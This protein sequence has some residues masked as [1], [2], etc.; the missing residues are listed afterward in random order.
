ML[1]PTERTLTRLPRH[2]RRY[3]VSQDYDAYNP[4]DHAVWRFILRRL[5]AHL[6]ERAHPVYLEGLTA[7][8]LGTERIPNLDEM[9]ERLERIGWGAVGVRGFIPPAVFTELLS[10]G[11]LPI[12]ADIRTHEHVDYTPAPDIVHESAGHAPILA[13]ARYA[14]FIKAMAVVSFKAIASVEDQAVFEAIRGL[15][16]VKED[17]TASAEE[18]GHAEARLAAAGR[19]RR[20]TSENTRAARFAWWTSEYGLIGDLARPR[21]YGAGLLSS[22]GEAS[23]C[24]SAEVQKLPLS[25]GCVDVDYDITQM[26]P[27]LFVARDFDHL[28]EVLEEFAATLSFRR[29][30]DAGLAEAQRAR[31]VNHLVLADG[32]E[33]TGR[34]VSIVPAPRTSAGALSAAIAELEGP[35]MVSRGGKLVGRPW[36]GP[37]LVVFGE[38]RLPERGRFRLELSSGLRLAGFRAEGDEVLELAAELE[39]RPVEVPRVA[40]LWV[41]EDLPSVA[42]GPADP[43]SWD[44]WF[45]ALDGFTQGEGEAR[46]REA[47]ALA[48]S[49]A[50]ATLYR[51]L[52]EA[53]E[54]RESRESTGEGEGE[55]KPGADRLEALRRAA[56]QYPDEWLLKAELEE[57]D[58]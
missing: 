52:R 43:E 53:R 15:S 18:I 47:K 33:V 31:T 41:S 17:P 16:V 58:A 46:A 38:G 12:A 2:L 37:G 13:D 22:L 25:V 21:I 8:G 6:A 34:V 26:Q 54:S 19:S 35:G 51:E 20:F 40:Q 50:L 44:E 32:R 48:L 29:G 23:R 5:R 42:A 24:L 27:Q 39:G 11:V 28:F 55:G 3:V 1:T 57:L 56:L 14:A 7:T 49:P 30:G 4:R 45:G 10:V 36:R 9:N